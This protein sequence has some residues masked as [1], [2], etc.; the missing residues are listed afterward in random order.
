VSIFTAKTTPHESVARRVDGRDMRTII[1][2]ILS[3]DDDGRYGE[4]IENNVPFILT[5]EESWRDNAKGISAIPPGTYIVKRASRPKHPD[6][7]EVMNVPGRSDILIHSGNT[8]ADVEGCIMLGKERGFLPAKDDQSGLIERQPAVLRS[9][10]AFDYFQ[11]YMA[12]EVE[13]RL[14]IQNC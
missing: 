8:E 4:M 2:K 12:G 9:R 7:W 6:T 10:E 11:E 13:F 3:F 5:Q 14:I 1:L